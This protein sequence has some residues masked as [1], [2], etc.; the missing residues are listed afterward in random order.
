MA[1]Y[2]EKLHNC[3][4][5]VGKLNEVTISKINNDTELNVETNL[6]GLMSVK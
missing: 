2:F 4:F 6:V 5:N 3:V 1:D